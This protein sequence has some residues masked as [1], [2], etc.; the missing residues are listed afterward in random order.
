M[1]DESFEEW[2]RASGESK[3]PNFFAMTTKSWIWFIIFGGTIAIPEIFLNSLI[4]AYFWSETGPS[5][6]LIY[7]PYI[8][9]ISI[10]IFVLLAFFYQYK[11]DIWLVSAFTLLWVSLLLSFVVPVTAEAETGWDIAVITLQSITLGIIVLKFIYDLVVSEVAFRE[12]QLKTC[13]YCSESIKAD[14]IKC[15]YCGSMLD[16]E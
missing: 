9:C 2:Q 12:A 5:E 3:I 7:T 16:E 14:A 13:P 10:G 1:I 4:H 8:V 15:R 6:G 11:V